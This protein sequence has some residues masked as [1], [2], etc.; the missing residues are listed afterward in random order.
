MELIRI[1]R[2]GCRW[3]QSASRF[4][5]PQFQQPQ[6]PISPDDSSCDS[7][8][9]S[10]P[11]DPTRRRPQLMSETGSANESAGDTSLVE[12]DDEDDRGPPKLGGA[13]IEGPEVNEVNVVF[14]KYPDECCPTCLT[15]RC[16][17]CCC[18][19]SGG[20]PKWNLCKW[21]TDTSC[22]QR[23]WKARC[24]AYALVEHRYFETFIIVMILSSSLTL[25]SKQTITSRIFS[26]DCC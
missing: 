20:G 6:P 25:V 9:I 13:L 12:A 1:S 14:L 19:G 5:Y 23:V 8:F 4:F 7:N 17:C 18:T 24:W 3:I 21:L 22:G 2:R 11:V 15:D 26:A 10:P 16:C